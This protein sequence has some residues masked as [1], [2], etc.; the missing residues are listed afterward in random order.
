MTSAVDGFIRLRL[1]DGRTGFV[2]SDVQMFRIQELKVNLSNIP[3]YSQATSKSPVVT[4]V[5]KTG[6]RVRG[7]VV[8]KQ[9][10]KWVDV[11]T[12]RG[13]A[14]FLPGHALGLVPGKQSNRKPIP[15]VPTMAKG[16]FFFGL[17]VLVTGGT[18]LS[19]HANKGFILAWGAL[20]VGAVAFIRGARIYLHH[21]R[22]NRRN[23][24]NR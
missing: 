9:E 2:R 11:V 3:L 24:G 4:V 17:G 22:L 6:L 12:D 15:G 13:H 18:F 1:L 5:R 14:G 21:R 20:I 7:I 10:R 23:S 8:D 19:R 16:A